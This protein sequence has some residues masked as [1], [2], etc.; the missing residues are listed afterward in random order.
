VVLVTAELH[1]RLRC[2]TPRSYELASRTRKPLLKVLPLLRLALIQRFDAR[3]ARLDGS[4][5]HRMDFRRAGQRGNAENT[6]RVVFFYFST[7]VR[8]WFEISQ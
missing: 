2:P 3:E 5:Q 4:R 8:N 6:D 1:L 7:Y